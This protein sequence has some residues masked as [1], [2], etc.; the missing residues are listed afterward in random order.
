MD[1]QTLVKVNELVAV[2]E[3]LLRNL[4]TLT[5][6]DQKGGLSVSLCGNCVALGA[7]I[8]P[9]VVKHYWRELGVCTRKLEA[10]GFEPAAVPDELLGKIT[11]L[12]VL[13]WESGVEQ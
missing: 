2:R 5:G 12:A 3:K 11:D 7:V 1:N 13:Q 9:V 6:L 8:R 10:L 4:S